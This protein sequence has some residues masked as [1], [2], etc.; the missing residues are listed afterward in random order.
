MHCSKAVE[1]N[2]GVCVFVCVCSMGEKLLHWISSTTGPHPF[3]PLLCPTIARYRT[4][5]SLSLLLAADPTPLFA[6]FLL[7][8]FIYVT[9]FVSWDLSFSFIWKVK[10]SRRSLSGIFALQ[11]SCLC[12][13]ETRKGVCGNIV[14]DEW[15]GG[16]AGVVTPR[17]T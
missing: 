4:P 11:H 8:Y 14:E 12:R 16:W 10:V 6:L 1:N 3:I 15:G 7:L 9:V 13:L 5:L 17:I 2:T